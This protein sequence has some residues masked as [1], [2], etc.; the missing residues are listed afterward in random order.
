MLSELVVVTKFAKYFHSLYRKTPPKLDV[1]AAIAA[2]GEGN[3]RVHL[4]FLTLA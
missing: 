1:D 2:S 3:A 4:P